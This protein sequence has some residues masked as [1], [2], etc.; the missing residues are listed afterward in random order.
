MPEH[1]CSIFPRRDQFIWK[2]PGQSWKK[3]NGPLLDHQILG[4]VS[5]EGRG[6]FRGCYWSH[7]TRHAVL[8]IDVESKYHQADELQKL[9]E[10]L[11]AVGLS[12]TPYQSSDSGG[13]HLYL[14]FDDWE[15]SSQVEQ[16]LKSWLKA[17]KYSIACGQ[18]EVF[19]SGNAL[20]LPLQQGF[21]W[22]APDGNLVRRREEIKADEALA[23]FLLD[24]ENNKRNW[25]EAKSL[26]E[27]QLSSAGGA[28]GA[29]DQGH[30]EAIDT[31][32]FDGLWNSGQIPE[33]MEEARRYLDNGLTEDGSR[34]A[35]VFSIQHLLWFGDRA[36][37]VPRLP[38]AH[39]DEKRRRFIKEWL[40][41]NH[42]GRSWNINRGN[43]RVLD[44]HIRRAAEWRR[45]DH[46]QA[47]EYVPYM[48]T[49]RAADA[50][51]ALTRKTG[52]LFTP[53]DLEKANQ[54]RE[55]EAREKIAEAVQLFVRQGRKLTIKGLARVSGCARDTVR[56]HWDIHQIHQI[57]PVVPL[58][59]CRGDLDPGGVG[60]LASLDCPGSCSDESDFYPSEIQAD[61]RRGVLDQTEA[62][63]FSA[64]SPC[65]P[66]VLPSPPQAAARLRLVA[67]SALCLLSCAD[68]LV[69]TVRESDG[70][71]APESLASPSRMQPSTGSKHWFGGVLGTCGLNGSLPST[72]APPLGPLHLN[73][74]D[75]FSKGS[76][77]VMLQDGGSSS[78]GAVPVAGRSCR[79]FVISET[80]RYDEKQTIGA[81]GALSGSRLACY[82]GDDTA[83]GIND[84]SGATSRK[85]VLVS[86]GAKRKRE[87]RIPDVTNYKL[88]TI[89]LPGY[90]SGL[91]DEFSL[92]QKL[93]DE[94]RSPDVIGECLTSAPFGES[95]HE[96]LA[97]TISGCIHCCVSLCGLVSVPQEPE[98]MA[99]PVCRQLPDN[100]LR[101]L[102]GTRVRGPPKCIQRL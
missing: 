32:G 73:P 44:G 51:I 66:E 62:S 80:Y 38:G 98:I 43:W 93:T 59:K 89:G 47:T 86:F 92:I 46:Q 33:R 20:R 3:A 96:H 71:E 6:L 91:S 45:H 50:L 60:G 39:N 31:E 64:V 72:A 5:D 84:T 16:T 12:G 36:R 53:E 83:N 23:S 26:I 87:N 100:H 56:K 24:F 29:G 102:T 97:G 78:A 22:L 55:E 75:I 69:A 54:K 1:F 58:S 17:E 9:Q 34:H 94:T 52:Y 65:S 28:A 2:V 79:L 18:L 37:G 88:L 11:A 35:A 101:H 48:V 70:M 82:S 67:D 99:C 76:G 68:R 15:D 14:F 90:S 74:R 40:E 85:G 8:D 19:P 30:E 49:E 21:G 57:S 41:K 95:V 61:P 25:S 13:W 10:K 77:S 42:N 81:A 27:S 7:K 4:V 63:L